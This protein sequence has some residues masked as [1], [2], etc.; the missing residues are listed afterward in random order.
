[1]DGYTLTKNWFDFSFHTKEC[2]YIHT[3]IYLWIVELNNRLQWKKE[4]GLPTNDTCEGLGIGNKMTYL[5]ALNEIE[6][7][8]FIKI[9]A[10]SKNQ[11]QA[12]IIQLCHSKKAIAPYI[13]LQQHHIQHRDSNIDSTATIVKQR[14]KETKKQ[15]FGEFSEVMKK[16]F[17]YKKDRRESYK[18]EKTEIACFDKL[19]KLSN[20]N[21]KVAEEI[22]EDSI[23]RNYAG[24]FELKTKQVTKGD[25]NKDKNG[26]VQ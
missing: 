10:H 9:L 7:W 13:A 18:S 14:N 17:D 19:K 20:N 3:A 25:F 23:S 26:N 12:N 16:W 5:K 21:F 1:M 4:F 6:A 2:K 8:G 15:D 22:I 24:F 11:Y